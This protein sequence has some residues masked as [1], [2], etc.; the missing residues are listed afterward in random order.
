MSERNKMASII[1]TL[2]AGPWIGEFG[3]ELCW[4]NPLVRYQA[5]QYDHIIV[6]APES[7]R[8]LYEFADNFIPLKTQGITYWEGK[9]E[10]KPPVVQANFFL[11]PHKEFAKHIDEPDHVSTKRLWRSL[12]PEHPTFQADI[13]CAFRPRKYIGQYLIAGKEYP[14]DLCQEVA[15]KLIDKGLSVACFGG[16]DN[17]C[18]NGVIDLRGQSL[19]EQC[20]AIA[21]AKCIVGPSSGPIHLASLCGRP[22]VTWITSMHHTLRRRYE[23]LWNP[24][25]ISVRFICHNR[26]PF[27]T[28]VVQNVGTLMC[29]EQEKGI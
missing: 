22:L 14:I 12:I 25:D 23:K 11:E 24:F 1:K 9:L 20:G 16:T 4:W 17:Y 19:E 18:P 8:Y 3:W 10:G 6:A 7:S 28:E 13:L 27:P 15:D 2:Y 21:T 29:K 26:L 5:K